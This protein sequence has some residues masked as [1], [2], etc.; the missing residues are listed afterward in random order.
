MAIC[1]SARPLVEIVIDNRLRLEDWI[2]KSGN[3]STASKSVEVTSKTTKTYSGQLIKILKCQTIPELK[4]NH[5]FEKA[6]EIWIRRWHIMHD[7]PKPGPGL[8][9]SRETN[10]QPAARKGFEWFVHELETNC[11]DCSECPK[12]LSQLHEATKEDEL[13]AT[14]LCGSP[15]HLDIPCGCH[16][17]IDGE[18]ICLEQRKCSACKIQFPNCQFSTYMKFLYEE[19]EDNDIEKINCL[20]LSLCNRCMQKKSLSQNY[21]SQCLRGSENAAIISKRKPWHFAC[22]DEVWR[23]IKQ[24]STTDS[25]KERILLCQQLKKTLTNVRNA[26]RNIFDKKITSAIKKAK[27]GKINKELVKTVVAVLENKPKKREQV[28]IYKNTA[29]L[30]RK[31]KRCYG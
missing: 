15:N 29:S 19:I 14:C 10:A 5:Y 1:F 3:N 16:I 24:S 22:G 8:G 2:S 26:L 28:K 23:A 25:R 21:I 13:C 12:L 18:E 30:C 9:G 6:V 31:R 11:C 17:L 20:E 4:L 27:R 7:R